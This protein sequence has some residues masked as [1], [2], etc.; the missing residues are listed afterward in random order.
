MKWVNPKLNEVTKF[1]RSVLITCHRR[2]NHGGN[3]SVII[4]SIVNLAQ[5]NRDTIF[6][7]P[8]HPNP[9]VKQ[10][11]LNSNLNNFKNVL[12]IE[13]IEYSDILKFLDTAFCAISDSGGI[14]EEAPSFNTPVIVLREATERPE[15]I[16]A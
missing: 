14:Q 3:L 7:W 8:L 13:P 4:E 10:K 15:G 5:N 9:N 16:E 1:N 11:V 12:L 2:E 6:V